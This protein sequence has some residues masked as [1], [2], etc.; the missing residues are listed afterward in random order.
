MPEKKS[1]LIDV[2]DSLIYRWRDLISEISK[3]KRIFVLSDTETTC[4]QRKKPTMVC[5]IVFLSGL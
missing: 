4:N 2:D 5:L 3:E 1:S